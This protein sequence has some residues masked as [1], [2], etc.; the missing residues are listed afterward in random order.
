MKHK[1]SRELVYS[2]NCCKNQ[3]FYWVLP[4]HGLLRVSQFPSSYSIKKHTHTHTLHQYVHTM[5]KEKVL[6]PIYQE[7][8]LLSHLSYKIYN[9]AK[10]TYGKSYV[11]KMCVWK[12][13]HLGNCIVSNIFMKLQN[14]ALENCVQL[15]N[16]L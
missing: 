11:T 5:V 16:I 7:S 3:V 4:N 1:F 10:N 6:P 2:W 12:G 14:N 15:K 9:K 13:K 8:K